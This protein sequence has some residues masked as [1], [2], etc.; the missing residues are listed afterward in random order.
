[1]QPGM[2]RCVSGERPWAL[3]D[4]ATTV[5]LPVHPVDT[6]LSLFPPSP[7]LP[8]SIEAALLSC[9]LA[10]QSLRLRWLATHRQAPQNLPI[11]RCLRMAVAGRTLGRRSHKSMSSSSAS[12]PFAEAI[13]LWLLNR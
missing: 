1:M 10:L 2:Y 13:Q 4:A 8:Q 11:S 6:A 7:D 5:L 9:K 12:S 3:C